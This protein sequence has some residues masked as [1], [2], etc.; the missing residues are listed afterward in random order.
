MNCQGAVALV[1]AQDMKRMPLLYIR[2]GLSG[3]AIMTRRPKKKKE[4]SGFYRAGYGF[5][6]K[7]Q[8][9]DGVVADIV[10]PVISSMCSPPHRRPRTR[11]LG[12]RVAQPAMLEAQ[13]PRS[14]QRPMRRQ[15]GVGV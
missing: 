8:V 1:A 2:T 14:S 13:S 11:R 4:I 3:G 12:R 10:H 7:K 9:L 6:I 15:K 5:L